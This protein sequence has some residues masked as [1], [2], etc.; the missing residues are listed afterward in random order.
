MEST[1]LFRKVALERMS[2]PEQLDRLLQ[3]TAPKSWLGLLALV[4]LLAAAI[5]WGFLGEVR[6]TLS[7]QGVLVRSGASELEARVYVPV[8]SGNEIRSQMETR[9]FPAGF[10]RQRYGFIRG[11]VLAVSDDPVV[12]AREDGPP[13]VSG[14]MTRPDAG[15][16]LTEVRIA[17]EGDKR[18][19]SGY[20]WSS[21][22]EA[23][24]R[25]SGRTS[26]VAEIVIRK[27]KPITLVFPHF[28]DRAG[29]R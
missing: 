21:G 4:G 5:A 8:A 11:H 9:V 15:G 19:P 12:Q 26:C 3:V 10:G 27:E 18:T 17:L 7:A 16:P 13:E 28:R 2:S 23:P 25:L 14:I 24:A 20:H 29:P 22:S 1:S 6:T